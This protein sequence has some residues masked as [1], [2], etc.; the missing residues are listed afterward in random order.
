MVPSGSLNPSNS[1]QH[2]VFRVRR[3]GAVAHPRERKWVKVWVLRAI[4]MRCIDL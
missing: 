1:N 3:A 4:E 2:R